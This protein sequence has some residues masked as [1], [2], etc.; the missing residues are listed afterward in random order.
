MWGNGSWLRDPSQPADVPFRHCG[1]VL[2]DHCHVVAADLSGVNAVTGPH[3]DHRLSVTVANLIGGCRV[4]KAELGD[5]GDVTGAGLVAGCCVTNTGLAN[6][7]FVAE[8]ILG[9]DGGVAPAVLVEF[10]VVKRANLSAAYGMAGPELVDV[11]CVEPSM[12]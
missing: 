5:T 7:R 11:G 3:L 6:N 8:A 9:G 10:Q 12:S 2:D 4:A 1:L